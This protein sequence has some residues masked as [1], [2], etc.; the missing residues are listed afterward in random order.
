ME[1]RVIRDSKKVED[2]EGTMRSAIVWATLVQELTKKVWEMTND[3]IVEMVKGQTDYLDYETTHDDWGNAVD[4]IEVVVGKGG[5]SVATV[6]DA[7]FDAPLIDE[8]V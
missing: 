1:I 6:F 4:A 2:E 8:Q 7:P 3:E 5:Y